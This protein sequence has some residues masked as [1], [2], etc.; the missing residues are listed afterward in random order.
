[1][2]LYAAP[3]QGL[4]DAAFRRLHHKLFPGIDVYCA[5]FL[6]LD[7]GLFRKGELRDLAEPTPEGTLAQVLPAN[8]DELR[9][10]LEPIRSNAFK[11]VNINIGAPYPPQMAHGRGAALLNNPDKLAVLLEELPKLAADFK[12]SLKM[13]L[14]YDRPDQWRDC[15]QAINAAPLDFVVMHP[16]FAKQQLDGNVDQEEFARFLT[17][18]QHP[19]VYNGDIRYSTD[20]ERLQTEFPQLHG[21]MIG[22][23]LLTNPTL[24]CQLKGLPSPDIA[25]TL[26]KLHNDLLAVCQARMSDNK[27]IVRHMQL[28]WDYLL[29]DADRKLRKA[30]KKAV[31]LE[32]YTA[33]AASLLNS[34]NDRP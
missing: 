29:P 34:L 25:T 28:Y 15:I 1:M 17:A 3:M 20:V 23:A 7:R 14:G 16:R 5:P 33:A 26:R 11:H 24:P 9:R 18:C 2:L 19:V 31:K 32:Q 27:Q 8:P 13:R 6:H 10:M 21:L 12:F 30:M 22:R 4:T